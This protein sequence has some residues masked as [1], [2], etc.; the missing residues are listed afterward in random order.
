MSAIS[1]QGSAFIVR[2]RERIPV[3]EAA[4]GSARSLEIRRS[5]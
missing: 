5:R 1:Q 3:S 2:L 4:C